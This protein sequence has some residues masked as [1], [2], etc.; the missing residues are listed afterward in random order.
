MRPELPRLS[1]AQRRE[2]ARGVSFCTRFIPEGSPGPQ[3]YMG[4][5]GGPPPHQQGSLV[6]TDIIQDMN[7]E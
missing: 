5:V 4:W 2:R 6:Y 1:R 3:S 7:V